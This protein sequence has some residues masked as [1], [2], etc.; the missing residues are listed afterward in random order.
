MG[1]AKASSLMGAG[2]CFFGR[3]DFFG[4]PA[5]GGRYVYSLRSSKTD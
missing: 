2:L 3:D 4:P 5:F 1:I